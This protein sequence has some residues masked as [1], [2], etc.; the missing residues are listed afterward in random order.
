MKY[1]VG[2]IG[3]QYG[4]NYGALLQLYAQKIFIENQG[5]EVEII[6]YRKNSRT[7]WLRFFFDLIFFFNF[8][9]FRLVHLKCYLPAV[10]MSQYE[11]KHLKK[12]DILIVGTDQLWRHDIVGDA[13]KLYFLHNV[14]GVRKMT[15]SISVGSL[16]EETA[17]FLLKYKKDLG[18]F[19]RIT[20]REPGV[21]KLLPENIKSASIASDPVFLF[22]EIFKEDINKNKTVN[23]DCAYVLLDNYNE[24]FLGKD[25][26]K[27][28]FVKANKGSVINF[29]N[30]FS[31][32]KLIVTD[33]YHTLCLALLK[34]VPCICVCTKS[35]GNDRYSNLEYFTD[36]P[37]VVLEPDQVL[38]VCRNG[39]NEIIEISDNELEAL[40]MSAKKTINDFLGV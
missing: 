9:Y 28:G 38:K 18:D 6:N 33:S 8:F 25:L 39:G 13:A 30:Y 27:E 14:K 26:E 34:Q 7:R 10:H 1:K 32:C 29:L 4:N 21:L 20:V 23:K 40:T 36:K 3:F 24:K 16:T 17:N 19:E 5:F 11:P 22:S 15:N 37:I 2:I 35:R 31:R 12:Y